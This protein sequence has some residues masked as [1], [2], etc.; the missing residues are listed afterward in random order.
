M[1]EDLFEIKPGIGPIK[2]NVRALIRKATSK[3]CDSPVRIVATRFLK[4]FKDHGVQPAQIQH[5]IPQVTLDA[6]GSTDKLLT[7]L[8]HP[9]LDQA[10]NLFGVKRAWLDGVS[11]SIYECRHCYKAP[12]QF[13]RDV[14]AVFDEDA[15]FCVRALYCSKK[16]DRGAG[17]GQDLALVLVK[18]LGMLGDS[19]VYRYVIYGDTWDWAYLPSRIQLKAMARM[20]YTVCD[21]QV[22]LFR[23][24]AK[25]L[26][27]VRKGARVPN[28]ELNG[29]LLTNPS[30]EDFALSLDESGQAQ[31][32]EELPAVLQYIE[33]HGLEPLARRLKEETAA[34]A[35]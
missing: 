7:V 18:R 14:A 12:V 21:I 31:E 15:H 29:C 20:A 10:T 26:D 35:Q 16:L 4:L 3:D 22:P 17:T 30:L 32:T 24:S 33:T 13:F 25:V 8:T 5:Y 19:E 23:V 6:L 28:E 9:V 27:E 11:D 2:L 1:A 34:K